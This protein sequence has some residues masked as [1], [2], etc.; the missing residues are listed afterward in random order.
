MKG[1]DQLTKSQYV[2][3]TTTTT[4]TTATT[5][6]TKAEVIKVKI[7]GNAERC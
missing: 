2:P 7:S 5:F 6:T 3:A 4:V 1:V